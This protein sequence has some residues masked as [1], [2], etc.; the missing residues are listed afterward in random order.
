M[1]FLTACSS[2]LRDKAREMSKG[3]S[4]QKFIKNCRETAGKKGINPGHCG[5]IWG[6]VLKKSATER[7]GFNLSRALIE[8]EQNYIG[9]PL[10][11]IDKND[12]PATKRSKGK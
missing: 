1:F 8:A 9:V 11:R 3:D 12:E 4:Y 7:K 10:R 2:E 5:S 6:K